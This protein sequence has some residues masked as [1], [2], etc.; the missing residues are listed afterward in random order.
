MVAEDSESNFG[1]T[2]RAFAFS[3]DET[4]FRSWE[5]KTLALAASK[6]F[7]LALTSAEKK[8]GLTVEEFEYG[9]VEEPGVQ[10]TG[11]PVGTGAEARVAA[12]T[13]RPTT[14][15]ENR[16]YLAR[17]A[18]WT[19]LVAS[20]TDKAYALIERAEGDPFLAWTILQEKYMATDAEENFPDLSD[21]FANCKLNETKKDPELWFNDLDHYNMRIGR[22]NKKYEKDDLQMKSHIMTSMSS[23]YDPVVLKYRGELATTPI[24]KLRKEITLQ[25]KA[26]VKVGS[27]YKSESISIR[28]RSLRVHAATVGR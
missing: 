25:Y 19:Y 13:T 2:V 23:G 11:V 28:T 9:E 16:R 6:G 20:C 12:T 15:A 21:A 18:A 14:T 5:G 17:A 1:T 8:P 24:E 22:I 7:L 27:K 26:L 3:G 10:P 4:M